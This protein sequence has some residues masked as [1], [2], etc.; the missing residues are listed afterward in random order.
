MAEIKWIK[1]AA[2]IFDNRKIRQIEALPDGDAI[3]VIWL[4][5]LCLAGTINDGGLI[6]FTREIPYTEEMIATQFKR[7]LQTVK[8]ALQV[9]ER[10]GMIT[11]TADLY[12]I[13]N[14]EKYQNIEGLDHVRELTRERVRR[15]R[16]LKRIEAKNAC[17]VTCDVTVTQGNAL[18]IEIESESE[19][20]KSVSKDTPKESA[21]PTAN[22]PRPP[23]PERHQHGEY[24]NVLLTAEELRKL[25]EEYPNDYQERIE[26]LS[27]YMKS[28]GKVYKDHLATIRNW[29]RRDGT[30]KA[31]TKQA[32]TINEGRAETSYNSGA[33]AAI[34][35]ALAKKKQEGTT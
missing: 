33:N 29:A 5:L 1:L 18:D 31:N 9:F 20:K 12:Q 24:K 17:N 32:K 19:I 30:Q 2:D 8:L 6:Y 14:W 21:T 25:S 13:S 27:R 4:K 26:E 34:Y 23:K 10:F 35:A 11:T 7:P 16:E 15:H 3:I 28:T 22:A